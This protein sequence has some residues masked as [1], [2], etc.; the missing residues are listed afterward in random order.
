MAIK[1]FCDGC[2]KEIVPPKIAT[3]GKPL[4]SISTIEDIDPMTGKPTTTMFCATCSIDLKEW[5]KK[6][7]AEH[8]LIKIGKNLTIKTQ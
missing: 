7:Q 8:G 2:G 3:P 6:Q 5:V 4:P 1:Y